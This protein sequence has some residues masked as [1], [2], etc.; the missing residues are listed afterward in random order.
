M[1]PNSLILEAAVQ[2]PSFNERWWSVVTSGWSNEQ[3]RQPPAPEVPPSWPLYST[4]SLQQPQDIHSSLG[5]GAAFSLVPTLEGSVSS[6]PLIPSILLLGRQTFILLCA[7]CW[8]QWSAFAE[9]RAHLLPTALK[10]RAPLLLPHQGPGR[11]LIPGTH[12]TSGSG[13]CTG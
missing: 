10:H 5:P 2:G 7:P 6:D 9:L 4:A 8:P 13:G 3:S 11:G 12:R 1:T